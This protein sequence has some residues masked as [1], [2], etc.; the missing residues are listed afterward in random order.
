[1]VV[2]YQCSYPDFD[3]CALSFRKYI[4]KYLGVMRHHH[5]CSGKIRVCICMGVYICVYVHMYVYM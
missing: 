3:G 5:V 1:M 2:L 4:L